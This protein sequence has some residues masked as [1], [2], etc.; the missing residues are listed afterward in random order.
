MQTCPKVEKP[1]YK[2]ISVRGYSLQHKS[3]LDM[4]KTMNAVLIT[5]VPLHTTRLAYT[6]L[7]V[8]TDLKSPNTWAHFSF[9]TIMSIPPFATVHL[10]TH[11]CLS[12]PPPLP[13]VPPR[14][15]PLPLPK[16]PNPSSPTPSQKTPSRPQSLPHPL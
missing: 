3:A 11:S 13:P 2:S 4:L 7:L 6:I 5:P 9:P 15:R 16:S 1:I 14:H 8:A 10:Q 12:P